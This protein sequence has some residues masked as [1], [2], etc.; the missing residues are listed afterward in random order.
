MQKIRSNAV[1]L[2]A[3]NELRFLFFERNLKE[4]TFLSPQQHH[5]LSNLDCFSLNLKNYNLS[6]GFTQDGIPSCRR[7]HH[8]WYNALMMTTTDDNNDEKALHCDLYSHVPMEDPDPSSISIHQYKTAHRKKGRP[9][10]A[11]VCSCCKLKH[12]SHITG[13]TVFYSL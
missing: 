7:S 1:L 11:V 4:M 12:M 9:A 13:V 3:F 8:S 6:G 5:H 10:A 2:R